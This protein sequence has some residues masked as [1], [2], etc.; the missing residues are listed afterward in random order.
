M[1]IQQ[2]EDGQNKLSEICETLGVDELLG[3]LTEECGELIDAA[4]N[5][6]RKTARNRLALM[7]LVKKCGKLI[8]AAQKARRALKGTTPVSLD[9]AIIH[10][11][12]ECADVALCI[13]TLCTVRLVDENGIQFIG[14]YKNGR[15]NGRVC[16][17]ERSET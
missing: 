5:V 1:L 9:E 16:K 7:E 15:W 3:Q 6:M 12:E 4:T 13:D 8:Q 10:L 17:T 2:E 14:R 11:T